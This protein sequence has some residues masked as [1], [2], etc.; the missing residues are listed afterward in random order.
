MKGYAIKEAGLS[1][2]ALAG[3]AVKQGGG[4]AFA[5]GDSRQQLDLYWYTTG[6]FDIASTNTG[7]VNETIQIGDDGDFYCT[8]LTYQADIAGALLTEA[9]NIIPLITVQ[10]IDTGSGRNLM[11]D[12]IPLASM[13][14]DGK[15]PMRFG[16][17]RVFT[18]N[19]TIQLKFF[20]FLVAGTTYTIQFILGGYKNYGKSV[21]R[22][23]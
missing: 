12:P 13:A 14:G 6:E 15:R 19:S 8:H 20:P 7:G 21:P 9:T 3:S 23:L 11:N 4:A 10:L 2:G 18:R 17:P 22:D 5:F 16:R 1:L